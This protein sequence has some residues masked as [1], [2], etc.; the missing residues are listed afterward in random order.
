MKNT[1]QTNNH[2]K[3]EG[4]IMLEKKEYIV[5]VCIEIGQL[6]KDTKASN[7]GDNFDGAWTEDQPPVHDPFGSTQIS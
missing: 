7:Q 6:V 3:I 2:E 4:V 1:I 5:P